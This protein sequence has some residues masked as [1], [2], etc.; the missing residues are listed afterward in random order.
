M[1]GG[2]GRGSLR[3]GRQDS[4][5]GG[6]GPGASRAASARVRFEQRAQAAR[7]RPWR[8]VAALAA[9]FAVVVGLG[10]VVWASPLLT[11]NEVVVTGLDGSD[12]DS[13]LAAAA[14]PFGEPLARLDSAAIAHRVGSLPIV[15]R[16]VVSRSWPRTVNIAVTPRVGFL[17]VRDGAGR[18]QVLDE[19]GVAFR[20]VDKAPA[21][22]AQVN[23]TGDRPAPEGIQA[24]IEVLRVLPSSQRAAITEITVTS[25]SLVSF[26]LGEVKVIWGGRGSE[27][28]KVKVLDVLLATKPKVIDVSAPDTPVTR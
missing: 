22:L 13:A 15:K 16:A 14:V 5:G 18:L 21:G 7:R 1:T 11:V 24:V 28:K 27:E 23:G 2:F 20:E 8:L 19:E 4:V 12:R 9:G 3:L 17:V 25:A 10:W 6:R 26:T